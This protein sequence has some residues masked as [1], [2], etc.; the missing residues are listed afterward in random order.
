VI[1]LLCSVLPPL[2]AATAGEQS[3]VIGRLTPEMRQAAVQCGRSGADCAVRPYELCPEQG[4][5]LATLVTPFSRV[6]LAAMEAEQNGQPL[7]RIGP[8]SVNRWGV[9]IHVL[10]RP[11][12]VTPDSIARVEIHRDRL[13][14]QPT[15]STVGPVTTRRQDGSSLESTR[16]VFGFGSDAF[17]PSSEITVVFTGSSQTACTL[18]RERLQDLR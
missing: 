13:V 17:D 18:G 3:G 10:P 7:G 5:Y 9:A 12:A 2:R 15:Q 1:T 11:G 6:A 14:I 4:P 16:G 8:A